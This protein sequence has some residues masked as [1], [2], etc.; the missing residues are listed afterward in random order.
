MYTSQEVLRYPWYIS[1]V[2]LS[3]SPHTNQKF[4]IMGKT[5]I[6]AYDRNEKI[7][8]R[9]VEPRLMTDRQVEAEL[10]RWQVDA[11]KNRVTIEYATNNNGE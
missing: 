8:F 11:T 10:K 2:R 4:T 1:G 9:S 5:I 6:T 3:A 7:V